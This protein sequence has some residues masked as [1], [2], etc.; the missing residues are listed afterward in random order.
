VHECLSRNFCQIEIYETGFREFKRPGGNGEGIANVRFELNGYRICF[1]LVIIYFLAATVLDRVH[2]GV[3][4]GVWVDVFVCVGMTVVS[5]GNNEDRRT[6]SEK[7]SRRVA[8]AL[9]R[10]ATVGG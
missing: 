8:W 9:S 2:D 4:D 10:P 6:R 7:R 3:P 5:E 1:F